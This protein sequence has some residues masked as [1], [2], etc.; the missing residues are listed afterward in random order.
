[1]KCVCYVV[2]DWHSSKKD[3]DGNRNYLLNGYNVNCYCT[4]K[5][6]ITVSVS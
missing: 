5:L 1:M 6:I 4:G 2:N 3:N